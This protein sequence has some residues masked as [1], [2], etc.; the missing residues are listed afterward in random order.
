MDPREFP[1]K[2]NLM[3]AKNSLALAHQ[4]YDPMDKKR[5]ILLK[6][7]MSLIDEAKDIQEQI[8]TTFTKAYACLQRANIEHGISKVGIYR[9][10]RGFNPDPDPQY[11]GD[12]DTICEV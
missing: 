5:N 2:G 1:T 12:G 11:H 10:D 6:E 8:D 7:L 9:P 4:G 3:L